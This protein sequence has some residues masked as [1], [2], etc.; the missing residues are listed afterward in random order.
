MVLWYNS[1]TATYALFVLIIITEYITEVLY[2][3]NRL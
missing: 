1:Y 3:E 2:E